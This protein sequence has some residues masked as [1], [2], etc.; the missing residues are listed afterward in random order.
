MQKSRFISTT[1]KK[2]SKKL[3]TYND[4]TVLNYIR[5]V[6]CYLE[7]FPGIFN[8]D[9]SKAN[10][11][12]SYKEYLLLKKYSS[13]TINLHLSAI[14]LFY[15]EILKN[16]EK[17]TR[18]KLKKPIPKH[19]PEKDVEKLISVTENPKHRL[20]LMLAYGSGLSLEDLRSIR[21]NDVDFKKGII[22]VSGNG[23][24]V[25]IDESVLNMLVLYQESFKIKDGYLLTNDSNGKQLHKRSIQKIYDAACLKAN[26]PHLGGI[27]SLRHSFAVHLI[28]HGTDIKYV[29]EL[30]GHSNLKTTRIY[31]QIAQ[32]KKIKSPIS[33]MDKNKIT[34]N[35]R[36][37]N[38]I[39]DYCKQDSC[40]ICRQHS[41]FKGIRVTAGKALA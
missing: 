20:V 31:Q 16:K 12:K 37:S 3:I 11:V 34:G 2:F 26:I 27:R 30:L 22:R 38:S 40:S 1:L 36:Y 9:H 23:R 6:K 28:E 32:I 13:L 41:E 18:V 21:C 15:Q 5:S 25:T 35:I 7:W 19:H 10:M 33:N 29:Q 39:C 24:V 4:K 17:T 14:D 8:A